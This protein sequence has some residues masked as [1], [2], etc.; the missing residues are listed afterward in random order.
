MDSALRLRFRYTLYP[1]HAAFIFQPG[2][3][4]IAQN[5]K[6]DL[7]IAAQLRFIGVE[8]FR[9]PPLGFRVHAV[10]PEQAGGEQRRLLA[11]GTAANFNNNVPVVV[12]IL[13]KQKNFQLLGNF[14]QG[15][16][17]FLQLQL[18]HFPKVLF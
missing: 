12:G 11:A 10:H 16:P 8:N 18:H 1:V 13:G 6:A 3:G 5:G 2:I 9:F 7:L 15:L 4:T 14:F 17:G